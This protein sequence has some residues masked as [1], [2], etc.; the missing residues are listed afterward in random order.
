MRARRTNFIF[1]DIVSSVLIVLREQRSLIQIVHSL[2]EV[3]DL[4]RNR[5]T[6]ESSKDT[7]LQITHSSLLHLRDES[8]VMPPPPLPIH[9][10]QAAVDST[11]G[12]TTGGGQSNPPQPSPT[13]PRSPS[14][15]SQVSSRSLKGKRR[16]TTGNDDD[17]EYDDGEDDGTGRRRKK[18]G[19]KTTMACHFCRSESEYFFYL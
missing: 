1:L 2:P 7:P 15:T 11:P 4:R 9:R 10:L 12:S 18:I 8:L 6:S 14:G 17:D 3:S 19:K 5:S 16:A 13:P